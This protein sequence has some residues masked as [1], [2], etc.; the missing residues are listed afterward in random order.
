MEKNQEIRKENLIN[1][2]DENGNRHG[3]WEDYYSNGQLDYK[4]NFVNGKPHG[5]WEEY[6]SN[7]E[8]Y[9]KANYVNGKKHGCWEQ[10]RSSGELS[11]KGNYVDGK[12]HGYWESYWDNGV[13]DYKGFYDMGN[14]VDYNPD[15]AK[16]NNKKRFLVEKQIKLQNLIQNLAKVNLVTCG[17]CGVFLLHELNVETIE[18]Y[19]CGNELDPCDC[20]DYW[21]EGCQNNSEFNS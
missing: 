8:L 10:Y 21:Y 7:G 13:L 15:E 14:R 1:L 2:F 9:Y 18:C 5:Y 3:Y 20:P 4:G 12:Q 6:W 16:P 17:H 11:Y 19:S